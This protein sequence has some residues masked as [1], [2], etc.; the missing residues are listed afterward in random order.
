MLDFRYHL[1]SIVSVFLALA[2][3]IVVGAL[4]IKPD[5]ANILNNATAAEA[6]RNNALYAHNG[7]LKDQIAANEAF[8]QA[9]EG[10]L[11]RGLLVGQQVVLVLAPDADSTTVDGV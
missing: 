7:Q 1:V 6:K 3:G 4:A 5:L 10:S 2:I 8:G 9:A 11:L